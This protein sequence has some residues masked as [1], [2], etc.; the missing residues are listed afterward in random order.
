MQLLE[1]TESVNTSGLV[2]RIAL[3]AKPEN[4]YLVDQNSKIIGFNHFPLLLT[5]VVFL[6]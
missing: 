5:H 3:F 4:I 6:S 1:L 2:S